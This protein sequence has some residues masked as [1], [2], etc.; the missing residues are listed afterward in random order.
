MSDL[1]IDPGCVLD[2][3]GDL[4]LATRFVGKRVHYLAS[5]AST[6]ATARGL[7]D[8]GEPEGT[9]VLADEQ[10]EG[11]GRSGRAWFSPSGLGVWASIVVRPELDA[12]RVAGLGI[13]TAVAIADALGREFGIDA[14]VKW[15]ND[16]LGGGRKLGGIL[17]E[18]GQVAGDRIESA[19]IGIGVNV[20]IGRDGFP[21][22]L[23]TSATSLAILAGRPVERLPVLRAVLSAFEGV[24]GRYARE[25][26]AS[27]RGRWREISTTLGRVIEVEDAGRAVVGT[28][29]D[30]S[31]EG[32]LVIQ[33][34][35]GRSVEVW[36]GDIVSIR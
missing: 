11:R 27:V 19:V 22:E 8:A 23:R 2:G 25:G 17:V 36:H 18:A 20:G 32:A 30:L 6:N 26:A 16:I 7:V 12:K 9:V 31:P 33:A 28:V 1:G 4:G 34:A 13:A 24:Y 10:A 14:W 15:P 29:T 3:Q 35:D 5:V 21:E